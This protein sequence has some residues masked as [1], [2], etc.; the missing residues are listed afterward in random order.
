[1]KKAESDHISKVVSMG[2]IVCA[3][4]DYA[5]SPAEVHHI[6][7]GTMGKKASNYEVI[8]LCPIHHRRGGYGVAIHAGRKEFERIHGSEQDLLDQTMG[9][10]NAK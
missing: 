5:D 8:A 7:N 1:M 6:G 9:L 3:N 2:C 4:M 10:L